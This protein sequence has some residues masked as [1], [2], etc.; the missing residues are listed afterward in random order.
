MLVHQ[1]D[2]TRPSATACRYYSFN[3][4]L[5]HFLVYTAEA[6]AY[7]SGKEFIANQLAFMKADLAAV[8]RSVTPVRGF[9]DG[10]TLM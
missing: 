2:V 9:M 4:G 1:D 6:Y 7:K 5:V 8:D 10:V 3:Q